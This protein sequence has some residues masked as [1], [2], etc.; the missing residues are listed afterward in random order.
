MQCSNAIALQAALARFFC[1]PLAEAASEGQ[2]IKS[3][4]TTPYTTYTTTGP[5]LAP[6]MRSS[7]R[8]ATMGYGS[9]DRRKSGSLPKWSI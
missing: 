4:L 1:T 6:F 5:T 3:S 7:S 9:T 2:P 8:S